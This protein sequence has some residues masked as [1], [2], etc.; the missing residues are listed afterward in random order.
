ME[1]EHRILFIIDSH[2]D[3]QSP[4]EMDSIQAIFNFFQIFLYVVGIYIFKQKMLKIRDDLIS[5]PKQIP[6]FFGTP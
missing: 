6:C 4:V 1:T 3:A 5:Q 2:T